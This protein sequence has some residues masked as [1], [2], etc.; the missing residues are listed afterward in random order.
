MVSKLEPFVGR[1]MNSDLG[2]VPWFRAAPKPVSS[3]QCVRLEKN[4]FI[5]RWAICGILFYFLRLIF[6]N[7]TLF[8]FKVFF[9]LEKKRNLVKKKKT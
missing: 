9:I 8:I 1:A 5:D 3:H 6:L 2:N 4:S 7:I